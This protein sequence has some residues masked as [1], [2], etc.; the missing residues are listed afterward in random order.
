MK[1]ILTRMFGRPHG[2]LGRLGGMIMARTNQKCAA[3]VIELLEVRPNDKILEVGFGPGVGIEL[4][5][6]STPAEYITG[7][8]PS[9]EMVEAAT[10]R[11]GKAI[12]SGHVD[13]RIGSVDRLPFDDNSFDKALAINSMQTWSDAVAGLREIQR[14]LKADCKIALGFTPY[15]GQS[16]DGVL[17]KLAAAG[18]VNTCIVESDPG[19]CALA[20]KP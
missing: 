9:K 13:L 14:V 5:N 10:A 11:N 12:E 4:L 1:Q 6:R 8:D 20:I 7:I 3:W 15:S 19:F 16:K 2:V 17:E 18:F